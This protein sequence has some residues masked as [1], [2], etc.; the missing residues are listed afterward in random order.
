M[1]TSRSGNTDEVWSQSLVSAGT[2]MSGGINAALKAFD[3]NLNTAAAGQ[4]IT[5][6]DGNTG[7]YFELQKTF[8][9]VTSLEVQ[10]KGAGYNNKGNYTI[11][12]AGIT[13]KTG[14]VNGQPGF[15]TLVPLDLT[16]T[17]ISNIKIECVVEDASPLLAAIKINGE[18]LI[19]ANIQDTVKDTPMRNY[20][21]LD[22]N[23][24]KDTITLKNGNLDVVIGTS[25]RVGS[26]LPMKAG[27]YYIE[28]T[29][30][31]SVLQVRISYFNQITGEFIE[32]PFGVGHICG[33]TLDADTGEAK[34]YQDGSIVDTQTL[35]VKP[36]G[37][38]YSLSGDTSGETVSVNF[39]QQPFAASNVTHDWDAGTVEID[40]E[41]YGTLYQPLGSTT[42]TLTIADAGTLGLIE[43]TPTMTAKA[44]GATGTYASHTDTE[45]VLS[46]TRGAWSVASETAISDT[47]HTIAAIDPNDFVMTSSEFSA[48]PLEA[49]H[50]SSTWQV[51]EVADTTYANPVIDVT[52]ESALT[53][54][55]AGGLEGDTT[56]RARVKHTSTNNVDS[57]WS[58]T[59]SQNVFKTEPT[60]LEIPDADM[61][62]LRFNGEDKKAQLTRIDGVGSRTTFTY[63]A[64]V[65]PT[66]D[67]NKN[68]FSSGDDS[69]SRVWLRRNTGGGIQF[70]H[71][72]TNQTTTGI[73]LTINTWHHVFLAV[74]TT[75]AAESDRVK[76]Y[77]NGDQATLGGTF[78]TQNQ[79]LQ[80]NNGQRVRLGEI[81]W[82]ETSGVST[83]AYEG[84][85]SDVYFVDGQALEPT[86]FGALFPQDP[87]AADRRWG[88]LDSSVVTANINNY[89]PTPDA[90]PN[91]DQKWSDNIEG[92]PSSTQP[93]SKAFD[94]IVTPNY[95]ATALPAGQGDYLKFNFT[96]FPDLDKVGIYYTK[97]W[98][99]AEMRVN[100]V[101]V[102]G[103]VSAP[104][105]GN[106]D[107][108][109]VPLTDGL[110]SIEVTYVSQVNVSPAYSYVGIA[111]IEVNGSL[112]VDGPA[113]T[114]RVWSEGT[115]SANPAAIGSRLFDGDISTYFS[116][117]TPN[118]STVEVTFNPALDGK[119]EVYPSG[120][121]STRVYT[122]THAGGTSTVNGPGSN[123]VWLDFGDLTGITKVVA[124]A[125]TLNYGGFMSA[126]RLNGIILIDG[127]PQWNTSQVWSDGTVTTDFTSPDPITF[128]FNGI[129]SSGSGR[130]RLRSGDPGDQFIYSFDQTYSG[131]IAVKVAVASAGDGKFIVN[132]SEVDLVAGD[133]NSST[134]V[135]IEA[136]DFDQFIIERVD[137]LSDIQLFGV[138]INGE[139][140]VDGGSFGANGFHLPFD[141][142]ATGANY[143]SKWTGS[144]DPA[145]PAKY[146][147]NGDL[148]NFTRC[149]NG[150]SAT[151]DFS[152]NPLTGPLRIYGARGSNTTGTKLEVNSFDKTSDITAS[153]VWST[154]SGITSTS[155]ITIYAD[156]DSDLIGIFAIEV[157]GEILID[158]SSIGTDASG[159]GN[160][161]QD[162]KLLY[163]NRQHR[164][165]FGVA[166]L[167]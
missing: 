4:T 151:W 165:R 129:L 145:T 142:A 124:G 146:S 83:V 86:E 41:T 112:L 125:G 78:P 108:I 59:I 8:T 77:V 32:R 26:T 160:H 81:A 27:K 19:D 49:T 84:Y 61:H 111:G 103:L 60:L 154:I 110:Q 99:D 93:P 104:S 50:G 114:S 48:T 68:I 101:A 73:D 157:D 42:A 23:Q 122:V 72:G 89:E 162:D 166:N 128:L 133:V 57:D 39:G 15:T 161:F 20:A 75:Q 163:G 167:L 29:A 53:T 134:W 14:I 33:V 24:I 126:I 118:T 10:I 38:M 12:G 52:S 87:S 107:F 64:W 159:Q 156:S 150:T 140:L 6:G 144:F 79:N 141:P 65:K 44:G 115:Y 70:T 109:E 95:T 46:N 123:P 152:A 130:Y 71:D 62:G 135:E 55:N 98:D 85:M 94:G 17:T 13:S 2:N 34:W 139:I 97:L 18:F 40:G 120:N 137:G 105:G 82:D 155:T 132:G 102:D 127:A 51:T 45:L 80:I 16:S 74:D 3:G 56:Y 138:R 36:E 117:N 119:L 5:P 158:H 88:P 31:N 76:I 149:E 7:A 1:K 136:S 58:D 106:V 153:G 54:Y 66:L 30:L 35:A 21:V 148:T 25:S 121:D 9:N 67:E 116:S 37:F 100:G 11:S 69:T 90:V 96:D 147:A 63:S 113:N 47:E 131:K 143:S 164:V 43:G 22:P 28:A 92:S 91:Y